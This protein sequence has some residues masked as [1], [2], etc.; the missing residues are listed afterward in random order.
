M[1]FYGAGN[2]SDDKHPEMELCPLTGMKRKVVGL[3]LV[4]LGIPS[5][6]RVIRIN[7]NLTDIY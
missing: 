6:H 2:I 7:I 1:I 3:G 5:T 4:S